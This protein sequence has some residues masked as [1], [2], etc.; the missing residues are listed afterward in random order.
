MKLSEP[1]K[2]TSCESVEESFWQKNWALEHYYLN[3]F[4][5]SGNNEILHVL[6]ADI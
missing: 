4:S 5:P 1:Q 3:R 6:T 2:K